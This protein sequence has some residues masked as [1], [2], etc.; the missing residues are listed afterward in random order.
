MAPI[1]TDNKREPLN[2]LCTDTVRPAR[3]EFSQ[4][5]L[6]A[7]SGKRYKINDRQSKFVL[8]SGEAEHHGLYQKN[9]MVVSQGVEC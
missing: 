7:T 3:N 4:C 9:I 6:S 8:F 5:A 2:L 1:G